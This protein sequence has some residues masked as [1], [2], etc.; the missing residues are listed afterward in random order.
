MRRVREKDLKTRMPTVGPRAIEAGSSSTV[1]FATTVFIEMITTEIRPLE[2][3]GHQ[4]YIVS[5]LIKT[6]MKLPSAEVR[7]LGHLAIVKTALN[8][9]RRSLDV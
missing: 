8:C 6:Y 7:K 1:V 4:P 9:Q 3:G 5:A 2:V